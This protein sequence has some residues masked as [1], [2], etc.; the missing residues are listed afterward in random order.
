VNENHRKSVAVSDGFTLIELMI[1]IAIVAIIAAMAVPNLLS[2]RMA[3]NDNSAISSLR[4]L[5]T[6]QSVFVNQS[7]IDS[8]WDGTGEYGTFAELAGLVPLNLRNAAGFAGV[9]DPPILPPSLNVVDADGRVQ[10]SGFHFQVF[11]PD[12]AGVGLPEIAGG[13][14]DPA[15]DEDTAE[16]AWA[17]YAWPMT[18]GTTGS[19]AYFVNHRG[20]IFMTNM[21]AVMY[22]SALAPAFSA[23]LLGANLSALPASGVPGLD[24]NTW[25]PLQ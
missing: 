11:L 22:S 20:Q 25:R 9:L 12:A 14:P 8:D 24:G 3:A 18:P 1:V 23:A 16:H 17:C 21:D 5:V 6:A 15:V 4:M 7:A 19:R 10:K 13:G 2:S